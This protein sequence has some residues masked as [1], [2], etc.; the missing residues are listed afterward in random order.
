VNSDQTP[1]IFRVLKGFVMFWW[2]F[3][4]GDTPE[5]FVATLVVVG[6]IALCR[7]VWQLN[8]LALIALPVLCVAAL[9]ISL[10]RAQRANRK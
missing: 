9:G 3:L 1:W 6:F 7:I 10:G 8:A 4:V 5:L 2:D